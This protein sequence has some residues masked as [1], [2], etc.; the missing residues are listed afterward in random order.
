MAN[1]I[2]SVFVFDDR[3]HACAVGDDGLVLRSLDGGASW[4]R[5]TVPV[6]ANLYSARFPA[7]GGIGYACG[8]SGVLLRTEDEGQSW[9]RLDTGT[10]IDLRAVHFATLKTGFLAGDR[11]TVLRTDDSGRSWTPQA[12]PCDGKL[13]DVTFPVDELTGYAVGPDCTILKTTNGGSR[14]F[15]QSDNVVNALPGAAFTAIHFPA[16]DV[17]GFCTSGRGRVL[18]TSDGGETWRPLSDDPM[19][20]PLY[21]L[22]M[23]QDTQAGFVVGAEGL[24][25]GTTDGGD[26]WLRIPS[27]TER[28]LYTVRFFADGL[29]GIAGGDELTLLLTQDAGN[30]W[31]PAGIE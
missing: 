3:L 4:R 18:F 30:T 27:P 29:V 7:Q 22:D 17:V 23:R 31:T 8:N 24:I 26:N 12:V 10:G 25:A 28:A 5:S 14:W 21:S 16:D 19:F 13:M 11:G 9:V 2:N 1:R 15:S 6:D 20:P